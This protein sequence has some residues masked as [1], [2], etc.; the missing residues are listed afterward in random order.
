MNL[1]VPDDYK[2]Y[3]EIKG[4]FVG[5]CVAR[6]EGS[7]FRAKA[8]AHI[9]GKFK[10]WLCFLSNK[11]LHVKE[12][13]LHEI[14]HLLTDSGHDDKWRSKVIEIGGT[15]DAVEGVLKSYHRS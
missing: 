7:R 12:L 3:E 13:W 15:I 14:A 4:V 9:E 6:G 5:G 1:N 11:W 8:H 10:G 2:K